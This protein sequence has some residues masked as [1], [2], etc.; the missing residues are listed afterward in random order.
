MLI[1]NDFDSPDYVKG[2][3]DGIK[4]M[5]E[6]EDEASLLDVLFGIKK[7]EDLSPKQLKRLSP[8]QIECIARREETP[9]DAK[10]RKP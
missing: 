8:R 7:L 5:E 6:L 4:Y 2:F 1:S 10:L 9:L 3:H